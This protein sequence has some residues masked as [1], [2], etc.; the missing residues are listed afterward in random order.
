MP[1][2]CPCHHVEHRRYARLAWIAKPRLAVGVVDQQIQGRGAP[3]TLEESLQSLLRLPLR[4]WRFVVGWP[5]TVILPKELRLLD[6]DR[7][8]VRLPSNVLPLAL[9][10]TPPARRMPGRERCGRCTMS[11]DVSLWGCFRAALH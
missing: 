1:L 5:G 2:D 9:H 10:A 4:S 7:L 6:V 8:A 11:G 3:G